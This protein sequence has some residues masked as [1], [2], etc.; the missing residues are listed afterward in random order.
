[1]FIG[2]A[3]WVKSTPYFRRKKFEIFLYTHQLLCNLLCVPRGRLV[4]VHDLAQHLP[5]L[6]RSLFEVPTVN[7]AIN[8]SQCKALTF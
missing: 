8:A 2:I 7:E 6:H 3:I 4:A 1:M 5:L